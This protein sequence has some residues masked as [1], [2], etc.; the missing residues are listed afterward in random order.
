[1]EKIGVPVILSSRGEVSLQGLKW[2]LLSTVLASEL[3]KAFKAQRITLNY[4]QPT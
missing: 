4:T 2:I 3:S 1:M